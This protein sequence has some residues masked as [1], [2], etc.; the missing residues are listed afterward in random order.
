VKKLLIAGDRS[1]T[2]IALECG[3]GSPAY[4]TTSFYKRYKITP[5]N[6]RIVSKEKQD[7]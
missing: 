3:F 7:F 2:E 5:S 6:F 4:L 1:I